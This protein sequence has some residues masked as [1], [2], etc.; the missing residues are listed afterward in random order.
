[1]QCS[2][3]TTSIS[4]SERITR[5]REELKI[6]ELKSY[7]RD[8]LYSPPSLKALCPLGS[9]PVSTDGPL[10]LAESGATIGYKYGDGRLA[11][12]PTHSNY[13]DCLY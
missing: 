4:Q 7:K 2:P 12:P 13:V 8:P 9:A 1:M 11:L 6:T 10:T 3:F 5:L